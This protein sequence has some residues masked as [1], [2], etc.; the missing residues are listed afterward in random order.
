MPFIVIS[1]VSFHKLTRT[2]SAQR[3]FA[4][5]DRLPDEFCPLFA[6]SRTVS[7]VL[8]S[9]YC[10]KIRTGSKNIAFI[11]ENSGR[12]RRVSC[13]LSENQMTFEEFCVF[14]RKIR[15]NSMSNVLMAAF[16][17]RFRKASRFSFVER[18]VF[19]NP[20]VRRLKIGP[21]LKFSGSTFQIRSFFENF[22]FYI[23]E[24]DHF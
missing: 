12:I 10:R 8:G 24:S 21:F 5:S 16:S 18:I 15:S 14:C 19:E 2:L 3:G 13:V 11:V 4:G 20:R 9:V 22:A 23:L 17:D 7:V 1:G 6:D